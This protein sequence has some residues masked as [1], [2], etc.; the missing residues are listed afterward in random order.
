MR[1]SGGRVG[2]RGAKNALMSHVGRL[3]VVRWTVLSRL[4]LCLMVKIVCTHAA[5]SDMERRRALRNE[6]GLAVGA[7]ENVG[8]RRFVD[9]LSQHVARAEAGSVTNFGNHD[10]S[11]RSIVRP[12]GLVTNPALAALW[13]GYLLVAARTSKD[14]F[15]A[16]KDLSFAATANRS[17]VSR[18]AR[19]A[20][21]QRPSLS[22][23]LGDRRSLAASAR[24]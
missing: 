8:V 4:A 11:L 9:D 13:S 18:S 5:R 6:G 1:F 23:H 16:A 21:R 10:G 19:L 2:A 17:G 3:E 22:N 20:S 15:L 24:C 12:S 7:A 14:L